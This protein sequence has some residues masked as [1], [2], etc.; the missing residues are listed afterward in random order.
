MFR[1]YIAICLYLALMQ[2]EKQQ[3]QPV[4]QLY[5][6]LRLSMVCKEEIFGSVIPQENTTSPS[7]FQTQLYQM[8]QYSS[9][10][11][12]SFHAEARLIAKIATAATAATAEQQAQPRKRGK[13]KTPSWKCID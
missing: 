11:Q 13:T 8:H 9:Y 1:K 12:Q 7:K 6:F 10:L 3:Q 2:K 5:Y 4:L